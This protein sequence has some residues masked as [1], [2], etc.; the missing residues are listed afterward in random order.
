MGSLQA[1][2]SSRKETWGDGNL[3]HWIS[4]SCIFKDPGCCNTNLDDSACIMSVV[5][6]VY[7]VQFGTHP[8][9][10]WNLFSVNIVK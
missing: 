4:V 2:A 3:P 10:T 6:L 5:G 7:R 8:D 9:A 1:A